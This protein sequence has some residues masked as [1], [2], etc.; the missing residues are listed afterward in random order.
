[1]FKIQYRRIIKCLPS[2]QYDD[3]GYLTFPL[4]VGQWNDWKFV[5]EP[6]PRQYK[7]VK[8]AGQVILNSLCKHKY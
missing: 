7:T 1:M 2:N 8:E 5:G 6:K 4:K 3:P